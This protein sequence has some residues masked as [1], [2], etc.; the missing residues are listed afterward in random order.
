[1]KNIILKI[2]GSKFHI[3]F[4]N[5]RRRD[6]S[7]CGIG[8]WPTNQNKRYETLGVD[9]QVSYNS[10]VSF[11]LRI[12]VTISL[13][14]CKFSRDPRKRFYVGFEFHFAISNSRETRENIRPLGNFLFISF[15]NLTTDCSFEYGKNV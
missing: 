11:S 3:T 10:D 15:L 5:R 1:M 2:F 13:C 12:T 7:T 14:Q 4:P 6:D 8:V 9:L